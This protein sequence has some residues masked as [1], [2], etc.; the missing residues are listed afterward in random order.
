MNCCLHIANLEKPEDL[1]LHPSQLS[2]RTVA[3]A[4]EDGQMESQGADNFMPKPDD[5][6]LQE[7]GP[8]NE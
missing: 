6:V 1:P 2:G 7:F 3:P 5:P 8:Q 4:T